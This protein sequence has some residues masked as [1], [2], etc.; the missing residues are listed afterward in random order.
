MAG[1]HEGYNLGVVRANF[2]QVEEARK[3]TNALYAALVRLN[4][5]PTTCT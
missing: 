1:T 3:A 4:G 2:A 5:V